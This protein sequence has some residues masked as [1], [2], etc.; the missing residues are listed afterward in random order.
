VW[1][2][3]VRN[4]FRFSIHPPTGDIWFGDVG[5]NT[6][7]EINRGVRGANY[8]WP[9]YE[10]AGVQPAYAGQAPCNTL[11]A[12]AVTAPFHTYNHT[13]GSTAI[14]GPFYTAT[15]YPEEYRGNFF[16]CDY[17]GGFI[18]R[19]VFDAAGNPV[20]V[21]PFATDVPNPVGLV[22]GPDGMIYYLSFNTGQIRR[23]RS[24]GPSAVASATPT[25]GPSPLT[26]TFSSAGSQNPGGGALT[27]SWNF[28]DGSPVSTAAN[29][30]HTYTTATPHTYTATLTVSN[31][32][33]QSSSD[34]VTITVGSQPPTPTISAPANGLAVQ[35][36][37]TVSFTGSASDPEDGPVP[38]SGLAWTVLLHHNTHVHTVVTA[39]G[40][41]GSFVAEDHGPIGTFSY[42]IIL[43]ATD[44]SGLSAS[45]SVVLPVGEDSSPP[46]APTNLAATASA[47]GISLGWTAATDNIAVANYLVER[48]QGP[49]CSDFAQIATPPGTSY[50]DASLIPS[51]SYSYRVAAVDPSGN[52]SV[53]SNV[54]SV[55]TPSA[56]VGPAGLVAGYTFDA[57]SGTVVADLSGNG[58]NGTMTGATW[59]TGRYGGGMTFDGSSALVQVPS[60]STLNPGAQLTL[61]AWIRP[62]GTQSGWRTIMQRQPDAYF[63]NASTGAGNNVPGGGGTING[64]IH[65][66]N[67][68]TAAPVNQWTHVAM[69]Y[70][71]T[72]L[73]LFVN[74][75]QVSTDGAGGSVQASTNPLWIG[76]N[77]PY[78]EHFAGVI[79]E[80]RVYNR[81][82]SAAEIQTVMNN[83]LTPA[84]PD[85]TAPSA[86][87]GLTAT[88]AGANQINLTWTA[89]TD[90]VGV[91]GYEVERCL[92]S[93]CTTFA[94][95]GTTTATTF[96]STG[97]AASSS[98]TYRVRATDLAG[99]LS[100]Y[101]AT[102]TA[103]TAAAP[104]TTAPTAPTGLTATVAG[105]TQINLAWTASTDNIGVTGYR[106]E[107][108]Q[109]A[110]CSS[111]AQIA[112]PTANS[113]SDTGLV[114]ST[115]YRYR[116][117]ATDAAGNLSG[118][119]TVVT[120][121]TPASPDT[122]A[123]SV[124]AGLTA[125]AAGLGI[126]VGWTASTDN[127]GVTGYRV[128]RCQGAGCS[129]FSQVG[130]TT[131][132][133]YSDQ[134]LAVSTSYSYRVAAV[135]AAGNVSAFSAVATATT[136]LAPELPTGLVAGWSF[137][138][139]TGTTAA[140]ASGNGNTATL[141]SGATWATGRYGNGVLFDGVNDL[142]QVA[143]SSS[144]ALT[145]GMTLAAWIRPSGT[146]SGWRTIMQR[147]VDTFFLNAST[148]AGNNVPGGGGTFGGNIH[149][150]TASAAAPASQWTHVALTYDG[151]QLRLYV[152]GVQVATSPAGGTIQASAEPLWIG[153]NSPYG[154]YFA[155]VIDEAQMYNRPLSPT[156]V[157]TVMN[158]PLS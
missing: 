30:S 41:S 71:G 34:S 124:P 75:V 143:S 37:Q 127:V 132:P 52:T 145:S 81:A 19:V 1:L 24:N 48:C 88:A 96:A 129:A 39:T 53:F 110:G 49:G 9:C 3:G 14:G 99:N 133:G 112:T 102:A 97:L 90:N 95:V 139:G 155:G 103:A 107:R 45:T 21:Q 13:V 100:G 125:T 73:R 63:L 16:F 149:V 130:T 42:E 17:A 70:D 78:G 94:P 109:G 108:C 35:P 28:G 58:N 68:T 76:G 115:T 7:E 138:A 126:T 18:K 154:E 40:P 26:V 77:V 153:G 119:S 62:S 89:S 50:T 38:S 82:L 120:A 128:E 6:W 4:P 151:T 33:G 61:A 25:T 105:P 54:A 80:A 123:P 146:Q 47:S 104:D 135:D 136:G 122:T 113:H 23:I 92:G 137:N 158:T 8:G 116:V 98:Y 148:S 91:T 152:N 65:A 157:K 32:S 84:A 64:N 56:P 101:S 5:W 147:Q 69:T 11:P 67:G 141:L 2:Y 74:G 51:T 46:T 111:W 43:T 66:M 44:T 10:G 15:A 59:S 114:P 31:A 27:Y 106:L 87:T 29:P 57:G 55:T 117:R 150:T 131:T 20:S 72:S 144:L 22:L 60:S 93:G 36:G 156:E 121:T 79:D 85:T 83:P 134:G 140:D 118:F 86:P 142:A 12:S